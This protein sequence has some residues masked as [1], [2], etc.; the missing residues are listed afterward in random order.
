MRYTNLKGFEKHLSASAPHQLC[1]VYLIISAD[2]FERRQAIDAVLHYVLSPDGMAERF[3]GGD[4]TERNVMEALDRPALFCP[5]SVVVVDDAE[6]KLLDE[7]SIHFKEPRSFGY[8]IIGSKH[9]SNARFFEMHGVILDLADEKPWEKE[10]RW[11][12]QL[13]EKARGA[14]KRLAPDAALRMI[15][16]LDR[17]AALIDSE[18]DK[19]LCYCAHKSTIDRFDVESICSASRTHTL[20]QIADDLVWEKIFRASASDMRDASFFYGLL[21]SLRQQLTVGI[22]MHDLCQRKTPLAEWPSCFPKMWPKTI[23][24]KAQIAQRFGVEYFRVGLDRLFD[25]ELLAKNCTIPLDSLFD[26]FRL[27][28]ISPKISE[29]ALRR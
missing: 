11:I 10:K 25:I 9:K 1:R 18:M 19:L 14:G 12:E 29:L 6:K 2:D 20:W 8:L 15:E 17:D 23:E 22:K 3:F 21:A 26:F 16:R 13:H 4:A 7:L 5:Q 24:K 27:W 28:L